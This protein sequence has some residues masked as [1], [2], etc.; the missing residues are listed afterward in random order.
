MIK[1]TV[2]NLPVVE[3]KGIGANGKP[4]EMRFQTMYAHVLDNDGKSLPLPDKFDLVLQRGQVPYP[5]GDYTLHPSSLTVRDGRLACF[6][7]LTPVVT[8]P[9]RA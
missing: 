1:V 7:R 6:P 3:R 9:G 5:P 2:Y 4:Y 8:A